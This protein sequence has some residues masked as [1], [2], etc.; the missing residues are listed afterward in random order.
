M[1]VCNFHPGWRRATSAGGGVYNHLWAATV[2][3]NNEQTIRHQQCIFLTNPISLSHSHSPTCSRQ[4]LSALYIYA[5]VACQH[6]RSRPTMGAGHPAKVAG[7]KK[8]GTVMSGNETLYVTVAWCHRLSCAGDA[9]CRLA[10]ECNRRR[11]QT[12]A[13]VT[14]LAPYTMCKRVSNNK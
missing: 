4:R 5:T 1:N 10:V 2:H 3:Y 11:R 8:N 13:T 7:Q 12:P 14:S 9:A 6:G